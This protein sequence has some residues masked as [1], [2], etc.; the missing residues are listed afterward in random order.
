MGELHVAYYN[1]VYDMPAIAFTLGKRCEKARFFITIFLGLCIFM[2][3]VRTIAKTQYV[4][5]GK[6]PVFTDKLYVFDLV[7]LR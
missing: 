7:F 6:R 1:M 3:N 2:I 4:L 5:S